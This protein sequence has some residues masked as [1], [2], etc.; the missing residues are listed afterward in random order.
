[1]SQS[2]EDLPRDDAGWIIRSDPNSRPRLTGDEAFAGASGATVSDF[3][4]FAMQDLQMNNTRGYL[5]EFL[6]GRALGIE[7]NRVEWDPF[8]LL[9]HP[10][11]TDSVRIE[12]KSS[13]YL[14]SW[15][16]KRL[17]KPTFAGL[18]GR[19]LDEDSGAY[20]TDPAF[21]ADIYVMCLNAQMDPAEFDPLDINMWRFFVVP[22]HVLAAPGFA[23]VDLRW[24]ERQSIRPVTFDALRKEVDRVWALER[25]MTSN[26]GLTPAKK[27]AKENAKFDVPI[28]FTEV[29][30]RLKASCT[31][32]GR[33]SSYNA[34]QLYVIRSLHGASEK[35]HFDIYCPAHLDRWTETH[36]RI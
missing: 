32:C 17:S 35:G 2:S 15:R 3:W 12:V 30:D 10:N 14:Q 24:L 28:P 4:R 33:A 18:K 7:S 31:S 25:A 27:A 9:W 13:A 21:N 19:V 5:A 26:P 29:D 16:Q 1:M 22:R 34:A 23:S 8:D 11:S 6:V 20:S 36:Q